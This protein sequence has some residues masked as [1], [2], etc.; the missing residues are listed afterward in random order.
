MHFCKIE[1]SRGERSGAGNG[2]RRVVVCLMGMVLLAGAAWAGQQGQQSGTDEAQKAPEANHQ[3]DASGQAGGQQP[4]K[5]NAALSREERNRQIVEDSA[6]LLKLVTDLKIAV[7]NTTMD[8]LSIG[9]IRKADEIEKL[10]KNTREKVKQSQDSAS[11]K[12]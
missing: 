9:V 8:T 12:K 2:C 6:K 5:Q 10:A 3:A 7:D 11:S 1:V 4:A